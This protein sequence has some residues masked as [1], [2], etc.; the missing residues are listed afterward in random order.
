[1]SIQTHQRKPQRDYA[2]SANNVTTKMLNVVYM[3][4]AGVRR[5]NVSGNTNGRYANRATHTSTS[6]TATSKTQTTQTTQNNQVYMLG[7]SLSRDNN[8]PTDDNY[9]ATLQYMIDYYITN[10]AQALPT[11]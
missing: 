9:T 8:D 3:Q 2:D 1:M 10:I 5:N 6:V 11:C 7:C 4:V